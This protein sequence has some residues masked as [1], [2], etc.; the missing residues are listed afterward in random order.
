M[1]DKEY[2]EKI[3][4]ENKLLK[5]KINFLEEA[6]LIWLHLLKREGV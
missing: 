6:G 2:I 1:N 5:R 3:E 4:Q